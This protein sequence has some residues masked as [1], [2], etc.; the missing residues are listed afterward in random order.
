MTGFPSLI[1]PDRWVY[2]IF[3][4]LYRCCNG[5]ETPVHL[6]WM[7]TVCPSHLH[8]ELWLLDHVIVC[9]KLWDASIQFSIMAE[10]VYFVNKAFL[11]FTS[12]E[13]FFKKVCLFIS[14]VLITE[15]FYLLFDSPNGHNGKCEARNQRPPLGLPCGRA[16]GPG[17]SSAAFSGH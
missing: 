2:Y 1:C 10:P 14:E 17:L 12:S 4:L 6:F 3:G 8:S 15:I 5:H 11:F 13:T 9:F 7:V 16:Q